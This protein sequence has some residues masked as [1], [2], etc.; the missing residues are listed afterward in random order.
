KVDFH[1]MTPSDRQRG[2]RNIRSQKHD[3]N[4]KKTK[5]NEM[6]K[7]FCRIDNNS[8]IWGGSGA[9]PSAKH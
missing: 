1:S 7:D 4:H 9:P 6:T 8:G 3:I 2:R 5:V